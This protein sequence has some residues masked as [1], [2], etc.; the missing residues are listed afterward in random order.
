MTRP[1]PPSQPL[2]PSK[3][4]RTLGLS[5]RSVWKPP[6]SSHTKPPARDFG[7]DHPTPFYWIYIINTVL[8]SFFIDHVQRRNSLDIKARTVEKVTFLRRP[9]VSF[10][11]GWGWWLQ[12][13]APCWFMERSFLIG[14]RVHIFYFLWHLIGPFQDILLFRPNGAWTLCFFFAYPDGKMTFG[15]QA[16]EV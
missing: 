7:A 14:N 10:E 8:W 6:F 2:Q 13:H 16:T 1:F 5:G 15:V 4:T 12:A 9:L 11:D 3:C